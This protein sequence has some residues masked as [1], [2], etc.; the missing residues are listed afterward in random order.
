M[1]TNKSVVET[2]HHSRKLCETIAL[3]KTSIRRNYVASS[4]G[5]TFGYIP[6]KGKKML[7][8]NKLKVKYDFLALM[9]V[10]LTISLP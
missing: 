5:L 3:A 2:S 7:G 1:V 8:L 6:R 9:Q 4:L 10:N